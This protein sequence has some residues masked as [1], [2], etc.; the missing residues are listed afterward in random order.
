MNLCVANEYMYPLFF[1]MHTKVKKIAFVTHL[2]ATL[3]SNEL[4]NAADSAFLDL[5]SLIEFSSLR[6]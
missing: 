1:E 5:S 3:R 2:N 6:H 4:F